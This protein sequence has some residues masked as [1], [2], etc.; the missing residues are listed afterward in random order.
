MYLPGYIS[1]FSFYIPFMKLDHTLTERFLRYVKIDT[2]AD[3]FSRTSPSSEKQK[4]LSKL[5]VAE[6]KAIGITNIYTDSHGYVYARI[7]GNSDHIIPGVCFCA[8]ID[9]APDVTG[10]NVKPI[11]HE[12]YQGTD[13]VLPDDTSQIVSPKKY[14]ELSTKLGHDIITASGKTLLGS[15]DKSGVA[16][17]MDVAYQL[18]NTCSDIKRGPVTLLFTTDEEIGRGVEHVDLERI[19]AAYGFTLDGGDIGEYSDENFSADGLKVVINGLSAH[20]GYAK[21][22]MEHSMKIA[23]KVIAAL[24]E[25]TL[26][27]EATDMKQG[28][29][30]PSHIEGGLEQTTIEFI[31]RDFDTT[32]L[33]NYVSVIEDTVKEVLKQYPRSSYTM[34]R[35]TQYRNMNDVVKEHPYIK[36]IVIK[37]MQNAQVEPN[38]VPI[39]GGTDGAG[40]SMLGLP[41]PNLFA[42]EHGV[43]SR[44]EWTS[45]QDMEKSVETVL[46]II[47]L[48]AQSHMI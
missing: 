13:I 43:H 38:I 40:M 29:V 8:H 26:C 2:E 3:P 9:T 18:M 39:R 42:G 48:H 33:D 21:G 46:N 5:L 27:P 44:T 32:Q 36:D 34:E 23:A 30:H 16:V 24:P 12:N 22:K 17:I 47:F 20:P 6:L 35:E 7:E 11:V 19:N 41:F 25:D 4:D 10:K 15:D 37:A 31:I 28:F 14:K 45:V 1:P